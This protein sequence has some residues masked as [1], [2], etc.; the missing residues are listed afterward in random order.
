MATTVD[1]LIVRIK[2]DT[3]QLERSLGNIR[4]RT[5]AAFNETR[6]RRFQNTLRGVGN[7]A[8]IAA[9]S[10]GAIA[11]VKVAQTGA[12][13]E[14]LKLSLQS[15]FG[16]A[17]AGQQAFDR[18]TKFAQESP[19]QIKDL[20]KAFIQLKA[21][22]IE[23]T[24][25]MLSTFADAS[26]VAVDSLG[27]FQAMVRIT[28]R[29][30][31]GGLGLEELEQIA[32][33]GIPVYEILAERIGVTRQGISEMGQTAEGARKIMEELTAGMAERFGGTVALKMDSLNQKLSNMSDNFDSLAATIFEEGGIGDGFK[34]IVDQISSAVKEL[35]IFIR[36]RASGMGRDFVTAGSTQ[37]RLDIARAELEA[38]PLRFGGNNRNV[39]DRRTFLKA[40]ITTLEEQVDTEKKAAT[41][42]AESAAQT[43]RN[44]RAAIRQQA[45]QEKLKTL[46]EEEIENLATILQSTVTP[47]EALQK[48]MSALNAEL[49]LIAYLGAEAST[50]TEEELREALKRLGDE[51]NEV[52]QKSSELAETLQDKLLSAVVENVNGF[53]NDFVMAL[54]NGES[55][56]ESFK[57]FAKQ[58][59]SQIISAFMQMLVINKIIDAIGTGIAGVSGGTYNSQTQTIDFGASGGA[60]R[61][62]QPYIVGE[63]GPELFIPHTAGTLRN[64]NDTRSMGGG[65][66]VI[67][68]S[69][70]L[71]TG[72]AATV[73][74]EVTRMMPTI[75]EVTKASV[76]EAASR[77]GRFQKGLMGA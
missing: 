4:Q 67:N 7:A 33:R 9:V 72:V 29:S 56:L 45:A 40:L 3:R 37:E 5:D 23:P 71:T 39:N 48:Q 73:R 24:E 66:I 18:I 51:L 31:G 15:V 6:G 1:E 68:Q 20:T 59:V 17:A 43:E 42:A 11:A 77:G 13:F 26:S 49:A 16:S 8:K 75:S 36:M 14:Q 21:A 65:G 27:A 64:G 69:I 63:R 10:V 22:G 46:R 44:T 54:I 53:T 2:A 41:A 52:N 25:E 74:E 60:M 50:F 62:G 32:D 28:Q 58:M 12:E 76:L 34:F 55:A 57:N 19:F 30:T 35:D 38:T 47:A 70:N 61:R